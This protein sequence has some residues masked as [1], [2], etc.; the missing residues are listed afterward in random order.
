MILS[1]CVKNEKKIAISALSFF[2]ITIFFTTILGLSPITHSII[3][4][5]FYTTLIICLF[6]TM[7]GINKIGIK[8]F[9]GKSLMYFGITVFLALIN[10]ILLN[11]SDHLDL[12][13]EFVFKISEIFWIVQTVLLTLGIFSLLTPYKLGFPKHLY[14]EFLSIFLIILFLISF[15]AGWPQI[16]NAL[17][18]TIGVMSLIISGKKTHCGIVC[19]ST[20]LI[21]ISISNIFFIYRSWNEISYFGDISDIIL[22]ISWITITAGVYFVKKYHA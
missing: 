19:L 8:N 13:K 11:L 5:A 22:L 14:T 20:G 15:F 17:L 16:L 18:I 4:S 3:Q 21:F 7:Q 6:L 9:A 2:L 12:N 1:S 10:I